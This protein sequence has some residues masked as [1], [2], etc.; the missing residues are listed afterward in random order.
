MADHWK[1]TENMPGPI[2]YFSMGGY[3]ILDKNDVNNILKES[4]TSLSSNVD[5]VEFGHVL[6]NMVEWTLRYQL[7]RRLSKEMVRRVKESVTT[8]AELAQFHSHDEFPPPPFP[9]DWLRGVE[10]WI[11][12]AEKGLSKRRSGGAPQNVE[13]RD[14]L[15]KAIGLFAAGVGVKEEDEAHWM[16]QEG[17]PAVFRFIK[18]A[19]AAVRKRVLQRGFSDRIDPEQAAKA[20]WN[21][22]SDDTLRK[23]INGALEYRLNM[24]YWTHEAKLD[25]DTG[26]A[27]PVIIKK[28]GL[29]WRLHGDFFRKMIQVSENK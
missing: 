9:S 4:A 21:P 27:E 18:S 22:V 17:K 10:H 28:S 12:E 20:R 5:A 14:F 16:E 15:P 24:E 6:N 19:N 26:K 1:Q 3:P 13:Q 23:R 7:E 8:Y 2:D 11:E 29:A 25:P